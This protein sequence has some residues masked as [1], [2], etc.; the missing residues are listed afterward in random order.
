MPS[1]SES[2]SGGFDMINEIYQDRFFTKIASTDDC[3]LWAGTLS[4]RGYPTFYVGRMRRAHIISY[5]M[6]VGEVPKGL[7][8]DHTCRNRACVNP[9]HL[10]P[11]THH[12]NCKR[13][14]GSRTHCPQNHELTPENT[15]TYPTAYGGVNRQCVTCSRTRASEQR[16]K[17]KV[18]V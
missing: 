17:A 14:V 3:W 18:L 11:V 6:F 5:E 1:S 2:I 12:E 16:R 13:G 15:R 9:G 4:D 8:L 10:E 7:E